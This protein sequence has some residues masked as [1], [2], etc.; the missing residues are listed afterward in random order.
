[1]RDKLFHKSGSSGLFPNSQM[2]TPSQQ[3]LRAVLQKIFGSNRPSFA[4]V[5]R[6][7][8]SFSNILHDKG[9]FC[10]TQDT[11]LISW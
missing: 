7:G 9:E 3:N 8:E 4:E 11:V 2:M 10:E 5:E 6:W 1:M